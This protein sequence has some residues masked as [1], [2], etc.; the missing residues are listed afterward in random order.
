M[1]L[2]ILAIAM[3]VS[4]VA[5]QK[6]YEK[7]HGTHR[8]SGDGEGA[9]TSEDSLT[10]VALSLNLPA[11]SAFAL[12]ASATAPEFFL[13]SLSYDLKPADADCSGTEE[14]DVVEF[15]GD[16]IELDVDPSCDYKLEVKIGV[17]AE[18]GTG[19]EIY[20]KTAAP[21]KISGDD[22]TSAGLDGLSLDLKLARSEEAKAKGFSYA[23]VPSDEPLPTTT[24]TGTGTGTST[25]SQTPTDGHDQT[26]GVKE[27]HIKAGTGQGAW[28]TAAAPIHVRVGDTLRIVNDD[29][30]GHQ[31]HTN[32]R[33]CQHGQFIQPGG[34]GDCVVGT[35]FEG[36][37]YDHGTR[38]DVFIS[39]TR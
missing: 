14:S 18:S 19:F 8:S 7:T 39:A 24:G 22:L 29:T 31:L 20:Y 27:F 17:A 35:T 32:G 25:A 23:T 5:C 30:V 11:P 34:S 10:S 36:G 3:A 37:L 13:R 16:A 6:L 2:R 38:G 33:P 4:P 9:E 26:I 1:L 21:L 28:N 15:D 12:T